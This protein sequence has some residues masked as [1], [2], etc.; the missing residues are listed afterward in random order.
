MYISRIKLVNWKNFHECDVALKGRCFVIGANASGK[1]NFLDVF[2]FLKDIVKDGGGLQSAVRERG[3]ISKIRCLAARQKT[4]IRIDVDITEDG[5]DSP[6]WRYSIDFKQGGGGLIQPRAFILEETVFNYYKGE[7]ILNRNEQS[8][9]EDNET[10]QS[11]HL[12]QAASNGA[13]REVK[14]V[15]NNFSYINVVPQLVRGNGSYIDN[16]DE[17]DY[18]RN[19]LQ[20][21]SILN[22]N[23]RNSYLK[24][25][26]QILP[27]AV[28]QFKDLTFYK[29]GNG[30]PH[31]AARYMDWRAK[32]SK[33][34]ESLFSD[35]TIRLIGFLFAMLDGKGTVLIEEPESNLHTAVVKMLPAFVAK[36]QRKK[37]RQVII[38]THSYEILSDEGIAADE[39]VVLK[40]SP[41]GTVVLNGKDDDDIRAILASGLTAADATM[42]LTAPEKAEEIGD[43]DISEDG[44]A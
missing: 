22:E 6:K 26:N 42:G 40:P 3:G 34:D 23:T 29:D 38:T 31:L 15:F 7:S 21:I 1:S 35:G 30:R 37:K 19:F 18:G 17:D 20:R 5:H 39:L 12:E 14:D 10:R 9:D 24:T 43:I 28:P 36:V 27:L 8:Q 32:G 2:R 41:E 11:T 33:Q 13:F 44:R 25:I 16:M 4:D